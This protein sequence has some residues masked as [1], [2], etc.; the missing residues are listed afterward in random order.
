MACARFWVYVLE[1][2]GGRH[3]VGQTDDLERGVTEHA[4]GRS[5]YTRRS[6]AIKLVYWEECPDRSMAVRRE[7]FLKSGR[8]REWLRRTLAEQS[9]LGG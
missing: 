3:Y 8:G 2:E 9:A 7:R 4:R 1:L 6:K 5:R